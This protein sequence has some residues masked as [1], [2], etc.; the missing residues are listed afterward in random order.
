MTIDAVGVR[1]TRIA[2]FGPAAAAV[3]GIAMIAMGIAG[4]T[5]GQWSHGS[6]TNA[7]I[8]PPQPT[9]PLNIA[10]PRGRTAHVVPSQGAFAVLTDTGTVY[11]PADPALGRLNMGAGAG[12]IVS[13]A[14]SAGG[15]I[16]VVTD[17]GRV[18]GVHA[19]N[20]GSLQL[21]ADA[22]PVVGIAPARNGLGY[23]VVQRDGH[24]HAYGAPRLLGVARFHP[25]SPVVG[26]AAAAHDGYW[27]ALANG[28]VYAINAP[29]L[30]S[31][32]LAP[33]SKPI[34][35]IAS[36][37]AGKG[38][39]LVTADGTV[40]AF[41]LPAPYPT[42]QSFSAPVVGI[43]SAPNGAYWL[44][45]ADGH[46]YGFGVAAARVAAH[47]RVIAIFAN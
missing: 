20:L 34:V 11:A 4:L 28:H 46:V 42:G 44:A 1:R 12:T 27:I 41:G 47:G 30:G 43:A 17:R 37:L 25:T 7:A 10:L 16:W 14:S 15:G 35:G 18:V 29:D 5:I 33:N 8:A 13:A 21:R 2:I 32:K 31:A 38:Y 19:P 45:T 23:R 9:A 39:R 26:I 24:V 6:V 36:T 40:Y 3:V 22:S